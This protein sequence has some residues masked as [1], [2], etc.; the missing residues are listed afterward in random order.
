MSTVWIFIGFIFSAID[1]VLHNLFCFKMLEAKEHYKWYHYLFFALIATIIT[2]LIRYIGLHFLLSIISII[3]IIFIYIINFFEGSAKEKI[4]YTLMFCGLFMLSEIITMSLFIL[5]GNIISWQ[6]ILI[7]EINI[8]VADF[9][10]KIIFI[11]MLMVIIYFKYPEELLLST[12]Q[13]FSFI[14][15]F[16]IILIFKILILNFDFTSDA[17]ISYDKFLITSAL[18]MLFIYFFTFFLFNNISAYLKK[19]VYLNYKMNILRN[20][21]YKK[22]NQMK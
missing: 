21:F 9:I 7:P 15:L 2:F 16:S 12:R 11:L 19:Y 4:L 3:F 10:S 6:Y 1:V 20:I 18:F 13:W 14:F 22:K 8:L 17:N 5:V